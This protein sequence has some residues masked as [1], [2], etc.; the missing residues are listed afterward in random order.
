MHL[1]KE[2]SRRA[3]QKTMKGRRRPQ[4]ISSHS[5][6]KRW[7]GW[8]KWSQSSMQPT[9]INATTGHS[10]SPGA[11]YVMFSCGGWLCDGRRRLL[12]KR[13]LL[14]C[15][16]IP[17]GR[18]TG[19][20]THRV[21]RRGRCKIPGERS[22]ILRLHRGVHRRRRIELFQSETRSGMSRRVRAVMP[23][24]LG[25]TGKRAERWART[26]RWKQR[27]GRAR[28]D[29]HRRNGRHWRGYRSALTPRLSATALLEQ[30]CETTHQTRLGLVLHRGLS[31]RTLVTLPRWILL[32]IGNFRLICVG[33]LTW[34]SGSKTAVRLLVLVMILT[35]E[36]GLVLLLGQRDVLVGPVLLGRFRRRIW[37][38]CSGRSGFLAILTVD[39]RFLRCRLVGLLVSGVLRE[40]RR[41]LP[42][43]LSIPVWL[44]MRVRVVDRLGRSGRPCGSVRLS[45]R[46]RFDGGRLGLRLVA[47]VAVLLVGGVGP[48][49]LIRL[50]LLQR[51]ASWVVLRWE[52]GEILSRLRWK[53]RTGVM[54]GWVPI[55]G[56]VVSDLA[57]VI[58]VLQVVIV[59]QMT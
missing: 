8:L 7:V 34:L 3:R 23:A 43:I 35:G 50:V 37:L 47:G 59:L 57:V 28:R 15:I 14:H 21:R 16:V 13:V 6:K 48:V 45:M 39:L 20:V 4:H 31:R 27:H 51:T 17:T 22:L 2:K 10:C 32:L 42:I 36:M 49:G 29:G 25:R 46:R 24:G 26:N 55:V 56:L 18:R 52:V 53:S 41:G 12:G 40:I 44:L 58:R 54:A 38:V 11:T 19:R 5:R 30:P 9:M 33:L 1:N